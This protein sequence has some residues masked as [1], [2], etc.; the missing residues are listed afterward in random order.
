MQHGQPQ[1]TVLLAALLRFCLSPLQRDAVQESAGEAVRSLSKG[2]K[3][4]RN[5]KSSF[6]RFDAQV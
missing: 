1:G 6:G 3:R 2:T 4:F 5:E